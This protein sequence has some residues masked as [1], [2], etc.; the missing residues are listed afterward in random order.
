MISHT[1]YS[2]VHQYSAEDKGLV[3]PRRVQLPALIYSKAYPGPTNHS[4][5]KE[6]VIRP[7]FDKIITALTQ[8]LSEEERNP[9]TFYRDW[10]WYYNENTAD[11]NY[12]YPNKTYPSNNYPLS[13]KDSGIADSW[14]ALLGDDQP[15]VITFSGSSDR[16]V[17]EQFYDYA[18]E[19]LFGDGLPMVPPTRELVD[20]ML[21]AT[22]RAPDEVVGGKVMMRKGL[23]TVE[24]IAIN[25][26]MAG[27]KPEYFPVIL[28]VMEAYSQDLENLQT[29]F[30]SATAGTAYTHLI[31]VSGAIAEE[32]GMNS[33]AGYFGAGNEANNTIGRA[34]R[35]C[36]RNIGHL[37]V[38]YID[39]N[40]LGR[41]NDTTFYVVAENEAAIPAGWATYREQMGWD[42]G[43]NVVTITGTLMP[44]V[45]KWGMSGGMNYYENAVQNLG[46]PEAWTPQS[47]V[48][49]IRATQNRSATLPQINTITPAM[50]KSFAE[51]GITVGNGTATGTAVTDLRRNTVTGITGLANGFG[52]SDTNPQNWQNFV[53]VTGEDPGRS[54]A[55]NSVTHTNGQTWKTELITGAT[56]TAA[57]R[58]P[59]PPAAPRNFTV[60][61]GANPGEA[62][63]TWDEPDTTGRAV[64]TGYEVTA[65]DQ[66]LER[67]VTVPGGADARSVTL[68]HLDGGGTYTFRARAIAG[69]YTRGSNM[70]GLGGVR[71]PLVNGAPVTSDNSTVNV[72]TNYT[73]ATA[74]GP[75]AGR[76]AISSVTWD[77]PGAR[78]NP[79][80]PSEVFWF[81][82][83]AVSLGE[84]DVEW[85]NPYSDGGSPIIGWEYSTDDGATWAVMNDVNGI[86]YPLYDVDNYFWKYTIINDS[87]TVTSLADGTEYAIRVRAVN[88][89]GSGVYAGQIYELGKAWPF[90][91]VTTN[92]NQLRY[93]RVAVTTLMP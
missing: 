60:V 76:G 26:V 11:P 83:N 89:V 36:L 66:D 33:G 65:Q 3:H 56:L 41:Y 21:A 84:I 82:A 4:Y 63:L 14:N 39:T 67:W 5:L 64:I 74:W 29:Y 22:T 18:Q 45:N 1:S 27:A 19:Y 38:P 86:D 44:V 53:L 34:V 90:S 88:T 79:T 73:A 50:A 93:R 51:L 81:M 68:T 10:N 69:E 57:G 25:A 59:A 16:D 58:D 37:W 6:R 91:S 28:A 7:E 62:L 85:R 55:F 47:V 72:Y 24:K 9:S 78:I 61:P 92:A 8:P 20:E 80:T 30:H 43:Q 12:K 2:P 71:A 17:Y 48:A 35:L 54:N 32:I 40:R 23:P 52:N 15:D 31:V 13:N 42:K 75:V 77:S 70:F 46:Q 49:G 87:A